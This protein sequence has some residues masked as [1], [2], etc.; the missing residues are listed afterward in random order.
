M[1]QNRVCNIP[2]SDREMV[3][4]MSTANWDKMNNNSSVKDDIK[5]LTGE[6]IAIA[7]QETEGKLF[8]HG[9]SLNK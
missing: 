5:Q 3:K 4:V 9:N 2:G 6:E 1:E 7:K 8:L